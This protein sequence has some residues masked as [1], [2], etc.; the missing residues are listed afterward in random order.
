MAKCTDLCPGKAE[1]IS[2]PSGPS[3]G[4]VATMSLTERL[5]ASREFLSWRELYKE[6]QGCRASWLPDGVNVYG[7]RSCRSLQRC[8]TNLSADV[9]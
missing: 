7:T 3:Q 6:A 1:F 9:K 2:A 5:G 8:V 4:G